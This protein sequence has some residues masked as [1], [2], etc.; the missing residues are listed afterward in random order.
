[1][2]HSF[3][4]VKVKF[5]VNGP[6]KLETM[7]IDQ[8]NIAKNFHFRRDLC[9]QFHFCYL[10]PKIPPNSNLLTNKYSNSNPKIPI[11]P[12]NFNFIQKVSLQKTPLNSISI[13]TMFNS[14][15]PNNSS[16]IPNIPPVI[17]TPSRIPQILAT[18]K[19]RGY[20]NHLGNGQMMY[21]WRLL[22]LI[23]H[24]YVNFPFMYSIQRYMHLELVNISE[25]IG[26]RNADVCRRWNC[27][28]FLPSSLS[29]ENREWVN[30]IDSKYRIRNVIQ[31]G[32]WKSN[33]IDESFFLGQ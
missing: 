32:R 7:R 18:R 33:G 22:E 20:R 17:I 23:S 12:L 25:H 31:K 3:R 14:K 1:M 30:V 26:K 5:D 24:F 28:C 4:V 10:I 15:N 9:H 27:Y 21:S 8:L 29:Q 11:T 19:P 6:G 2:K 16:L 13:S